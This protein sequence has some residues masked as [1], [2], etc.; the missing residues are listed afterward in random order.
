MSLWGPGEALLAERDGAVLSTLARARK[1][2]VCAHL[3]SF[4]KPGQLTVLPRVDDTDSAPWTF[5][6]LVV[7]THFDFK[8]G[9]WVEA[10]VPIHEL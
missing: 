6:L 5:P 10:L 4:W 1:V 2:S 3:G 9:Q 8:R 7:H